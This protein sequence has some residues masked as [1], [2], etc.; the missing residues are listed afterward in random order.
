MGD[1]VKI[2]DLARNLIELSGL[3]PGKDVTIEFTGLRPGEKLDEEL[4][5]AG[6]AACGARDI[7]RSLSSRR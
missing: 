4:L 1:P 6:D 5:I 3:I 2:V 7:R